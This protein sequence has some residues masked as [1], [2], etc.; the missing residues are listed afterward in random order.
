MRRPAYCLEQYSEYGYLD[1]K[2]RKFFSELL[3]FEFKL[4]WTKLFDTL[5]FKYEP[6]CNYDMKE[7]EDLTGHNESDHHTSATNSDTL[8]SNT[9]SGY[10]IKRTGEDSSETEGSRELTSKKVDKNDVFGWDSAEGAPRSQTSYDDHQE[11]SNHSKTTNKPNLTDTNTANNTL[12]SEDNQK[13]SS[14]SNTHGAHDSNRILTRKGNIGV[15]TSQNMVEQER[16]LW[17]WNYFDVVFN[18]VNKVLTLSVY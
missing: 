10:T 8:D 15:M 5:Q 12:H 11:E 3:E 4:K 17:F 14:E 2:A 1:E 7:I 18:D 6:L 16:A 13:S 9:N